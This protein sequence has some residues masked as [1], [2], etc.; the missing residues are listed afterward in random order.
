MV[1]TGFSPPISFQTS[2][3]VGRKCTFLQIFAVVYHLGPVIII[4]GV[5]L[6][7]IGNHC[8]NQEL[9]CND[10][11][12]IPVAWKC[13]GEEDCRNGTDEKDCG[14]LAVK[15]QYNL[16]ELTTS[17]WKSELV[18]IIIFFCFFFAFVMACKDNS[19]DFKDISYEIYFDVSLIC[20]NISC[21]DNSLAHL[22]DRYTQI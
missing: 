19:H 15:R 6:P 7:S 17:D 1:T 18:K 2:T 10:G 20:K 5:V 22:A 8:Q 4:V 13:D 21:N 12:C 9:L 16:V 14:K 11:K 3:S